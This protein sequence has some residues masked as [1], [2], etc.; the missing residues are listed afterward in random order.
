MISLKI[1]QIPELEVEYYITDS[2]EKE[3]AKVYPP[4]IHNTIEIYILL[5]GNVSF[6]VEE[7]MYKLT[8]GDAVLTK[9]NELHNCI[10]NAD[11][12]HRHCCIHF[13]PTC[14][15]LLSSLLRH[16]FGKD[17][18]ISPSK[19]DKEILI[20]LPDKIDHATANGDRLSAF[21]YILELIRIVS[22]N[23]PKA[24]STESSS[25]PA[26]LKCVL[27][28]I[29]SR[30]AEIVSVEELCQENFVSHSTLC[31]LF[32][33]HLR[34]TPSLYLETKRLAQSR[35]L[36]RKGMSVTDACTKC[37]FSDYSSFIRLF[38]KRFGITPN[39]YKTVKRK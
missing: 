30:Y 21:T 1:P 29:N 17:N 35:I 32:K 33:K 14:E 39:A 27:E 24:E 12:V 10:L 15:F 5:E 11:T 2:H 28:Q 25:L 22:K 9:P 16:S 19:E 3:H 8:S 4:H 26:T 38:K 34:T 13:A 23:S 20:T 36:L 18:L 6:I 31:R 37:G 7:N